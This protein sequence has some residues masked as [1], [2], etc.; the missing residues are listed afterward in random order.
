MRTVRRSVRRSNPS[1]FQ[2]GFA[3][4]AAP[5]WVTRIGPAGR[6]FDSDL[7]TPTAPSKRIQ[8]PRW[9]SSRTPTTTS[10]R[11]ASTGLGSS[12]KMPVSS[13]NSPPP[14]RQP[15]LSPANS[16]P[17]TPHSKLAQRRPPPPRPK[18]QT[19]NPKLR[20]QRRSPPRRRPPNRRF[21]QLHWMAEAPLGRSAAYLRASSS[22]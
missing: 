2:R 15:C 10:S 3:L 1:A 17:Q 6:P 5:L 21:S 9:D 8:I 22:A 20:R 7:R 13:T 18:P 16:K 12:V 4:S 14:I 19:P 11:S